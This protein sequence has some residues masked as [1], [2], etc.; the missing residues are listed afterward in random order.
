[1]TMD[2]EDVVDAV[3]WLRCLVAGGDRAAALC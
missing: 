2:I 1:M 3:E